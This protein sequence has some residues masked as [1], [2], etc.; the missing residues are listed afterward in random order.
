MLKSRRTSWASRAL[1]ADRQHHMS[2]ARGGTVPEQRILD[3]DDESASS[4]RSWASRSPR[5]RARG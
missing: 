1:E 3:A 2:P 4:E 5:R